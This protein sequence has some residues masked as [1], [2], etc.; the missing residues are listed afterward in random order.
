MCS[1]LNVRLLAVIAAVLATVAAL[2]ADPVPASAESGP[3]SVIWAGPG[4]DYSGCDLYA[5]AHGSMID[6]L[7]ELGVYQ[8]WNWTNNQSWTNLNG[9]KVSVV[10]IELTGTGECVNFSPSTWLLYLD[11]CVAGDSNELFWVDPTG[12][13]DQYWFINV[14][15]SDIEESDGYYVYQFMTAEQFSN[16]A[17][18][19]TEGPSAGAYGAYAVWYWGTAP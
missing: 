2:M 11:S 14:A 12:S 10:E 15:A 1:N 5:H 6:T 9:A 17:L 16:Y 4:Y 3:G 13:F 7:C 18:V 8:E 19:V